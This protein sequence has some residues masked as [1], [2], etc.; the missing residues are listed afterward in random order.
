MGSQ[1]IQTAD[2]Q[3]TPCQDAGAPA[4]LEAEE[5]RVSIY[6]QENHFLEEQMIWEFSKFCKLCP[7]MLCVVAQRDKLSGR[8]R[9]TEGVITC[10]SSIPA[11]RIQ[12]ERRP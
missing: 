8:R 5:K 11:L 1:I 3:Q 2:V 4:T 7:R 9:D 6:A 12:A 10:R